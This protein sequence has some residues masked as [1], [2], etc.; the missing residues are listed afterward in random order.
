MPTPGNCRKKVRMTGKKS[1]RTRSARERVQRAIRR[2]SDAPEEVEEAKG[3]YYDADERPL[4]EDQQD[5]AEETERA[6]QLLLAREEVESLLRPDNQREAGQE[7]D[8]RRA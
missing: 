3:L 4:D 5:A 2:R 6:A 7:Q 8:L 1:L